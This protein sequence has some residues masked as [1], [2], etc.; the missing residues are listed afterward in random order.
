MKLIST[1]MNNFE[2]L[3]QLPSN[4]LMKEQDERNHL[5][6]YIERGY[7]NVSFILKLLKKTK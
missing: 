1:D 2:C 3:A 5:F 7:L 6:N 4:H